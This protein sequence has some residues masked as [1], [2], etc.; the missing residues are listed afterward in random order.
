MDGVGL[1]R[2]TGTK[3]EMKLSL[4]ELTSIFAQNLYLE[5]QYPVRDTI[6]KFPECIYYDMRVK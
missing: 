6:Q 2:I 3:R 4:L 1:K 5:N